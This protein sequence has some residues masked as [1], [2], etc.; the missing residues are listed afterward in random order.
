MMLDSAAENQVP[1]NDAGLSADNLV[2]DEL[3]LWIR[4]EGFLFSLVA[5]SSLFHHK[6]SCFAKAV[7]SLQLNTFTVSQQFNEH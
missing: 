7:Y 2:P 6:V 3:I 1:D 4:T 5:F